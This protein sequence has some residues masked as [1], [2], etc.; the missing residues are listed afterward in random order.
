MLS[1]GTAARRGFEPPCAY[2]ELGGC[3]IEWG[4]SEEAL[5]CGLEEGDHHAHDEHRD[6]HQPNPS[7]LQ[8]L[9]GREE[10]DTGGSEFGPGDR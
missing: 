6:G 10:Q 7:D 3:H 9:C 1:G 5:P 2:A 8:E 4:A